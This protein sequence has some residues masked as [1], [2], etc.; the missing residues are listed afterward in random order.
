[1][2]EEAGCTLLLVSPQRYTLWFAAKNIH[3]M[4]ETHSQTHAQDGMGGGD[5]EREFKEIKGTGAKKNKRW[6]K[7]EGV[8]F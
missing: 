2:R 8:E 7:E 1:M 4:T 3:H 6:N 5:A